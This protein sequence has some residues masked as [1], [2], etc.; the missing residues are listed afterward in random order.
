MFFKVIT[1]D[2]PGV[3]N[4]CELVAGNRPR[5]DRS[6]NGPWHTSKI[7]VGCA[8]GKTIG[9]IWAQI[10]MPSTVPTTTTRI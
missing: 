10:R 5:N 2:Q 7:L 3:P 4:R 9:P 1:D 6:R 8:Q